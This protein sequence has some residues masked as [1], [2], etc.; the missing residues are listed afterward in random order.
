MEKFLSQ[1]SLS[2]AGVPRAM[3]QT[4][5][6]APAYWDGWPYGARSTYDRLQQAACV[7]LRF[8]FCEGVRTWPIKRK[9]VSNSSTTFPWK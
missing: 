5:N 9:A 7:D 2:D 3:G 4:D 1:S 6:L 8:A